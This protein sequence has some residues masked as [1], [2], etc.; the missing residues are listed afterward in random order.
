MPTNTQATKPGAGPWAAI[1]MTA[2]AATALVALLLLRF[3]YLEAVSVRLH[4][5]E[6]LHAA[7]GVVA[8]CVVGH[9]AR[10]RDDATLGSDVHR[11]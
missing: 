11:P 8:L 9:R 6:I 5:V 3:A 4:A 7:F 2:R 10:E 1:T